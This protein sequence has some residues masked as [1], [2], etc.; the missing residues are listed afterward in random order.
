MA[1]N[2]PSARLQNQGRAVARLNRVANQFFASNCAGSA[3]SVDTPVPHPL[4]DDEHLRLVLVGAPGVGKGTFAKHITTQFGIPAISTGD[5]IRKE[6]RKGSALGLKVKEI[7]SKGL[8]IDDETV[9]DLLV[10]RIAD[11]G[12]E[13]PLKFLL[14][15]VVARGH[16]CCIAA[17]ACWH[18]CCVSPIPPLVVR[19]FGCR[20]R[21]RLHS[22]WVM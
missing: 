19:V 14:H 21:E 17:V 2:A 7:V 6:I 9:M 4:S 18:I 15:V 1:S 8:L 5:L 12:T 10:Q 22:G 16:V 3:P 13:L 20:L 11:K